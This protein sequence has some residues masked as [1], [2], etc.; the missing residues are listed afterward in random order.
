M[1]YSQAPDRQEPHDGR[2]SGLGSGQW[3]DRLAAVG[4]LHLVGRLLRAPFLG[5]IRLGVAGRVRCKP[6]PVAGPFA[7]G[8]GCS[9]YLI[10]PPNFRKKMP[11][12]HVELPAFGVA[13][14]GD[15]TFVAVVQSQTSRRGPCDVRR[16]Q[17]QVSSGLLRLIDL[18]GGP[19]KPRRCS[20]EIGSRAS[21]P[22]TC[23]PALTIWAG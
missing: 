16:S 9:A 22:P 13:V 8:V 10:R 12:R 18:P 21:S 11:R 17:G 15:K 5:R 23:S 4:A 14:A 1:S 19:P 6:H 3:S 2:R 20:G 7:D